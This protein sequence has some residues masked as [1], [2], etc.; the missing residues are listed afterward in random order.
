MTST[1]HQQLGKLLSELD[2]PG[3]FTARRTAA[4]DDL[5]LE[6]KGLGPIRFPVSRTQARQ[7][8]RVARPARYG[9]GE[10]TLLDRRVR[11][12]WEIPKSRVKIDRR[13]WNR[14]LL[15]MLDALRADLGL[16]DGSK[17]KA[18]LHSM[19]VYAS[20][21]FFLPHQDSEKDDAMIGTLVVTLPS[22]F[23]GGGMVVEHQGEKI[24]YG[25]AKKPLTFVAFYAD[26]RHEVRPVKQGYRIVLT[27]NLT[28]T[29]DATAAG[30]DPATIDALAE[31]LRRH[32]ETPRPS[33]R[34]WE[35][36]AP[37][38]EPPNRLVYLLD[39][40]YTER[41]L[42][43]DRLKGKDAVRA[44]A[45]RAAAE[46][47]GCESVFALAEVK[48]T[49]D[50]PEPGGE[51]P[52]FGRHRRWQ[53]GAD[54]AWHSDYEPPPLG[55]LDAYHLGELEEWKVT[56]SHWTD[57]SGEK[58]E[59]ITIRGEQE[60]IC[61]ATPSSAFEPY[62]SE[63]EGYMGNWGNTMDRW[64]RRAAIILWPRERAFA[65]RA[66]ASPVWALKTLQQRIR[67]GELAT[68]REMAESLLPLWDD[69]ATRKERRGFFDRALR[70]ADGLD[71]PLLAASLLRPFWVEALTSG[72]ARP[73]AALARRY[74]EEWTW[75][76]IAAWCRSPCDRP[77]T[78]FWG[79]DRFGWLSS[80]P[81]LCE[82][83]RQADEEA[84]TLAARL[85]LEHL[86]KWLEE[87]I[88]CR[89]DAVLPRL[90][91]KRPPS[92]ARPILRYLECTAVV[93]ADELRDAALTFLAAEENAFLLPYLI[94]MLRLAVKRVAPSTR[95]AMGLDVLERHCAKLIET[96]LEQLA[97]EEEEKSHILPEACRCELCVTLA[98]FLSDPD[99]RW[100]KWPVAKDKRVHV[101][102]LDKLDQEPKSMPYTLFV[103][104]K[105]SLFAREGDERRSLE[106]DLE[107][108]EER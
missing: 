66:E 79:K 29:G 49:W 67:A 73:V 93:E 26:C 15:P 7:L 96:R 57:R 91:H 17:L 55:D 77:Q 89:R 52:L 86:W 80:L 63:Y 94:E 87:T 32:F 30:T 11:D 1:A 108:L 21:Q 34:T 12:T 59:P 8:C 38:R 62:V 42:G 39:H 28:V 45:L 13:R 95:T 64:Y 90:W 36:D 56:L 76:V 51:K 33:L 107:W 84:G 2:T 69:V 71:A 44:A 70:V 68:A 41:G 27:Y 82:A 14:T 104:K 24:V 48:E 20:G 3:S 97:Q 35:K 105:D 106:A 18:T 78:R 92:L 50:C 6:V 37:P 4:G 85:L 60:E 10:K 74:G 23:Q 54:G 103:E 46:R 75:S 72:R 25:A 98:A 9:Q 101:H 19:L 40:Q 16:P 83:L 65:V 58:A 81:R 99:Q 43:W 61:S 53:R 100:L 88:D 31:L 22:S 5:R 102:M 47:V